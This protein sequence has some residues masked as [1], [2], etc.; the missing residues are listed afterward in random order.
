MR[1]GRHTTVH[2]QL[3]LLPDDQGILL[4]SPGLRE[5]Q[6][7]DS[8]GL[9]TAFGDIQMLISHCQF[10]DCRHNKEPDCAVREALSSGMLNKKRW[11]NFLKLSNEALYLEQRKAQMREVEQ[12]IRIKNQYKKARREALYG[13]LS[14]R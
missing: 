8:S 7:W 2:R 1:G 9:E 14:K 3:F 11:R 6:L 10:K 13:Y 4:D 5:I 12:R